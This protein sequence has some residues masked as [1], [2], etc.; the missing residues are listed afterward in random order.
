[1]KGRDQLPGLSLIGRAIMEYTHLM[2][3][4]S[5]LNDINKDKNGNLY[6]KRMTRPISD[7]PGIITY[8]FYLILTLILVAITIPLIVEIYIN[9]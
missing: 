5:Y 7:R 3:T 8:R 4:S 1:M 6:M 9:I 2:M